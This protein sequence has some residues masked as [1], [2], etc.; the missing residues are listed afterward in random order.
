MSTQLVDYSVFPRDY[1]SGSNAYIFFNNKMID[2]LVALQFGLTENVVP[3][4][5]YASYTF[6]ALARG[7]RIV[8]GSFRINFV[9]NAYLYT[10]MDVI[11]K[12]AFNTATLQSSI[13]YNLTADNI[14]HA[15]QHGTLSK[16]KEQINKNEN[17]IWGTDTSGTIDKYR[18]PYFTNNTSDAIRKNGFDIVISYGNKQFH[19]GDIVNELP[20]TV[21]IINGVHLTG[22]SQAIQAN[23]E[24]IYEDYTFI[25]KDLN[26]TIT[27]A[28][29]N[30][31]VPNIPSS[32]GSTGGGK[33]NLSLQ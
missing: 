31:T 3:I 20:S 16:L 32:G 1:Y 4:F 5:G 18:T 29:I 9:E 21:T 28:T 19:S 24:T 14:A 25:A 7:S 27:Q 23:G 13:Q 33:V 22:V 26:N 11:S 15:V 30:P 10:V 8:T 2:Q 17:L 12:E 6:D